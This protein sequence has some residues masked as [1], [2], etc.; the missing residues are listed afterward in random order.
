MLKLTDKA[1]KTFDNAISKFSQYPW[2]YEL[3][4]DFLKRNLSSNS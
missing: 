2:P 3:K 1:I 4:I